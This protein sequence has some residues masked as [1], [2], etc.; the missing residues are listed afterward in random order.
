MKFDIRRLDK[1][2]S[3]N[4]EVKKVALSGAPEGLVIRALVQTS[5]R[6]S[7]GRG[8]QSLSGNLAFSV[9]LRPPLPVAAWGCYS[10]MASVAVGDML[11]KC[12]P[13]A[14]IELKWPNDVLVNGKKI[15]GILLEAGPEWLVI[16]IG[17]NVKETPKSPRYPATCLLAENAKLRP[18]EDILSDL[19]K[20]LGIWYGKMN[21]EG[22]A[23]VRAAWLMRARKGIMHVRLPS[24]EREIHGEFIDLDADGNLRLGLPD[25][26]E[27]RISAGDVFF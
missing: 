8:W 2:T 26:T 27:T 14:A 10:F 19:L 7:R 3:T 23:P 1:T 22:F 11:R 15:C 9:L 12:A 6:G 17:L 21:R 24:E 25:G 18:A 20:S 16:G 13:D 5:G 4:D